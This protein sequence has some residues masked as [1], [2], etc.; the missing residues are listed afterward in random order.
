MPK[1]KMPKMT[2]DEKAQ[3]KLFQLLYAAY[4]NVDLLPFD[5]REIDTVQAVH[6]ALHDC[7]DGLFRF[8]FAELCDCWSG[9]GNLEALLNGL[10]SVKKDVDAVRTNFT[11]L[12]REWQ[13]VRL[14]KFKREKRKNA[15]AK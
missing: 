3:V 10:T 7:G 12:I 11:Q 5:P 4:P 2:S 8:L 14:A 1:A 13:A 6:D 9:E 15:Q